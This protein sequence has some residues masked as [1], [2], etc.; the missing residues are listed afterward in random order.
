MLCTYKHSAP[1]GVGEGLE[2]REAYLGTDSAETSCQVVE[3]DLP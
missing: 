3:G 1:R 2:R